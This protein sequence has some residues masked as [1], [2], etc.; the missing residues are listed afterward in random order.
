MNEET[1]IGRSEL[2]LILSPSIMRIHYTAY[3]Y[4]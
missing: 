1:K 4:T 3:V 2:K